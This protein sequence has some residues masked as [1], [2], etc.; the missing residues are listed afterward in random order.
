MP[1]YTKYKQGVAR[2]NPW[3]LLLCRV[4][5]LCIQ[6]VTANPG[7]NKTKKKIVPSNSWLMIISV[8][9]K[10]VTLTLQP[11]QAP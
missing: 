8:D 5:I 7:S 1:I 2:R 10:I 6:F 11:R 9:A 3:F 4:I